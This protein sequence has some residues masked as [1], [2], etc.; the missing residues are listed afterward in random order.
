M[1]CFFWFPH[2]H[3]LLGLRIEDWGLKIEDWGLRTEDWGLRTGDW[4][5]MIEDWG[6]SKDWGDLQPFYLLWL[7]DSKTFLFLFGIS[8]TE[9]QC[10]QIFWFPHLH[11]LL[12]LASRKQHTCK[13][14]Y[15]AINKAKFAVLLF[16]PPHWCRVILW[17]EASCIWMVH[18]PPYISAWVLVL[19]EFVSNSNFAGCQ[20]MS[21]PLRAPKIHN[22]NKHQ[23]SLTNH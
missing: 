5:F 17:I 19:E 1:Q 6:L 4:G 7:Q 11:N 20:K 10:F 14:L 13:H 2:L 9:K 18:M 23:V 12:E 22:Q 15:L 21:I 16:K 3:N 8:A